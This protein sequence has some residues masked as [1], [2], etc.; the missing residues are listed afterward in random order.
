L[1]EEQHA[2]GAG[3][4]GWLN[5]QGFYIYRSN[6]II[7]PGDWLRLGR[8]RPW[9]KE[10]HYKLARICLDIP[11]DCDDKWALDIKKSTARPPGEIQARL[12]DIADQVR[13]QA[14]QV[15]AHRGEHGKRR[16][17][18]AAVMIRPWLTRVS[19]GRTRYQINRQHPVI[20]E[21]LAQLGPL[22]S[23]LDPLMRLLEE[24]VP[25]QQIWL[26]IA[27]SADN[28]ASPYAGM[29]ADS[30]KSDLKIACAHLRRT[31]KNRTAISIS[32]QSI[33][34]FGNYPELVE[35]VLDEEFSE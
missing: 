34:P 31:L 26:D 8:P 25:V 32:L 6:R 5:H 10:E 16:M 17:A 35:E 27:E 15:F 13:I 21:V 23:K 4:G 11:N 24:T 12:N 14:R 19:A 3:P 7:V 9:G 30:V 28:V 33:D 20:A 29:S 1:T 18:P 2:A 22:A